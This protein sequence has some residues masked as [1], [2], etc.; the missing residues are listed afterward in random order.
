MLPLQ[1]ATSQVNAASCLLFDPPRGDQLHYRATRIMLNLLIRGLSQPEAT[2][3]VSW[4]VW[5]T[6]AS[7]VASA[8]AQVSD[9]ARATRLPGS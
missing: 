9:Q 3:L 1:D 5:C 7:R 2:A 8:S 4:H 6:P